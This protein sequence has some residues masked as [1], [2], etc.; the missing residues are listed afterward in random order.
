MGFRPGVNSP[1][2]IAG[3][4]TPRHQP[5]LPGSRKPDGEACHYIPGHGNQEG[6]PIVVEELKKPPAQPWADTAADCK[7]EPYKAYGSAHPWSLK[8]IGRR[9]CYSGRREAEA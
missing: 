7:A 3:P 4:Y 2:D 6:P 5:N 8:N 1:S 9:R